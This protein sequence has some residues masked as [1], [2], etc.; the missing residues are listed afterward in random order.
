MYEHRNA[1][2]V[3]VIRRRREREI[4]GRGHVSSLLACFVCGH[5]RKKSRGPIPLDLVHDLLY[6]ARG[7]RSDE[8]KVRE[9]LS[10]TVYETAARA[11]LLVDLKG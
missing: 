10:P 1:Y 7:R 5:V 9:C 4:T 8:A 3:R 6:Y 2:G 11:H